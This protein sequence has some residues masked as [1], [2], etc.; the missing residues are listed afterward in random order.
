MNP[1]MPDP[2][3]T[4]ALAKQAPDMRWGFTIHTNY[5]DLEIGADDAEPFVALA[6]KLL[7]KKVRGDSPGAA[8]ATRKLLSK[9]LPRLYRWRK[10]RLAEE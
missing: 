1:P 9:T 3:L 4:Y 8:T 10:A 5:G 7:T 2:S 6:S